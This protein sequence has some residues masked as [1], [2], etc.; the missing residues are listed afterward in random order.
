MFNIT[1]LWGNASQNLN[2]TT[3]YT[4][5]LGVIK[6]QKTQVWGRMRRNPKSGALLWEYK[7]VQLLWKMICMHV[8][9]VVSNSATPWTAAHQAPLSV[10]LSRQDYWSG[11]T[12][13]TPGDL[14]DPGIKPTSF[15]SPALANGFSTTWETPMENDMAIPQIIQHRII[16]LWYDHSNWSYMIQQF[17]SWGYSPKKW[18]QRPEQ[19]FEHL[20]S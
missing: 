3:R 16:D 2:E 5:W 7:M 1:C 6:N 13:P 20:C 19:L 17:L 11:L 18:K 8:C 10:G 4:I 9:S 14:S 15:A 12:F